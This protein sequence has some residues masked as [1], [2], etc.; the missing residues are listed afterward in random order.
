MKK[1]TKGRPR[2]KERRSKRQKS[3]GKNVEDHEFR[4]KY[5]YR[6]RNVRGKKQIGNEKEKDVAEREIR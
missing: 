5:K 6:G 4:K 1:R 2:R 3:A